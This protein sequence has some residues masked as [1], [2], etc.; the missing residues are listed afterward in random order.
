M[1]NLQTKQRWLSE[2]PVESLLGI[3][4]KASKLGGNQNLSKYKNLGLNF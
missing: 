2:Q 4:N 1:E 3:I